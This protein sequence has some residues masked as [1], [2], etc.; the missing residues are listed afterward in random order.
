MEHQ[1]RIRTPFGILGITCTEEELATIVFLP[2]ETPLEAPD[3]A[4]GRLVC[5][6]LQSYLDNPAYPFDLPLVAHGTDF[7]QRVWVAIRQI[8]SGHTMSYAELARQ[9]G[10]GPRAVANACGANPLP[11]VIPCHRV[12]AKNGLG[13]FMQGRADSSL[14]IKR[15]LLEHERG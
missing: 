2:A 4:L 10:S 11:I 13:G 3:S 9:V 14:N 5:N 1:A 15:W 8:P 7:Q 12:V 6:A